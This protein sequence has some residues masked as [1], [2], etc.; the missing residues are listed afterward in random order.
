MNRLKELLKDSYAGIFISL[1]LC[2]MLLFYEPINLFASNLSDMWFDIYTFLPII[3]L[4]TLIPFL[5]LSLFF[6]VVRKINK[7]FY[8]ILVIFFLIGLL[9]TYVQGNFLAGSLPAI[10]G[11]WIDFDVFKTE[12]IISILLWLI[13][14][15]IIIFSVYKFKFEKME[16]VS[17]YASLII[18]AMLSSSIIGL[19]TTKGF[20]DRKDPITA[21]NLNINN[22]SSDKNF[23]IFLVDAVDSRTFNSEVERLGKKEKMFENFT[24]YPDTLAAYPFTRNSI[25]FILGGKWYENEQPFRDYVTEDI[26]NSLL[27]SKLESENYSINLYEY[28]FNGFDKVSIDRFDN[29]EKYLSIDLFALLKE[30]AKVI[31]YKYLPYQLKWRARADTLNMYNARSK[32]A[33]GLYSGNNAKNYERIKNDELQIVTGNNFQFIHLEGGHVPFIYDANVNVIE[34]G[35]YDGNI[36]ACITIIETYLNKL[37]DNN[38]YDN[39]VIV[40]MADHGYGAI[41]ERQNPILYIKGINEKHSYR[42]SDKKISY[43]DLIPAFNQL[44]DGDSTDQIFNNL[45]N[46]ERRFLFYL[47]SDPS[48]IT[49]QVSKG[50]AWDSST[51]YDTGVTYELKH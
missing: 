6:I 49:E 24:Y 40:I 11:S 15:A 45:D 2:F 21:T 19:A 34:D 44:I 32:S 13:V 42:V 51:I 17:M 29:V 1:C 3:L 12:K 10:D 36:D 38:V 46:E 5:L 47:F 26:N 48:L 20:F 14:S 4:Q 16:K 25:P 8:S 7:K 18:I 35:T 39:S 27:F 9:C 28:D 43:V 37:K 50:N 31:L 30:E 23:I 41:N 22:M 33:D